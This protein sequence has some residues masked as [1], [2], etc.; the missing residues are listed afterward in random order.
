MK[1]KIKSISEYNYRFKVFCENLKTIIDSF[2]EDQFLRE[3]LYPLLGSNKE[4]QD[5]HN[6]KS[7]F[8]KAINQ[9]SILTDK[10]FEESYLL[11]F[12]D[13]FN[14]NEFLKHRRDPKYSFAEFEKY[15]KYFK[16]K[17]KQYQKYEPRCKQIRIS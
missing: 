16:N 8:T 10:E 6:K 15:Q 14:D 5:K 12:K 17:V 2:D 13:F 9:F 3:Q 4:K 1:I 7:T 11:P